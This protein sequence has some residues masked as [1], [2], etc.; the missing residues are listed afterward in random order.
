M[1]WGRVLAGVLTIA[2]LTGG[3]WAQTKAVQKSRQKST[4]SAAAKVPESTKTDASPSLAE[5]IQWMKQ[6][7]EQYGHTAP[8]YAWV[9]GAEGHKACEE[10]Y[11]LD[12]LLKYRP[13][14]PCAVELQYIK[15]AS[16][17]CGWSSEGRHEGA[18]A[19]NLR[20]I[21][22][23]RIDVK[24]DRAGTVLNAHSPYERT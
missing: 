11:Q 9:R 10:S 4:P 22:P 19:I 14:D 23:N 17:S 1:R 12:T 15:V 24:V 5:T 21:D 16:V 20:D 13:G 3:D 8:V 18:T 7:L 2:L 6:A